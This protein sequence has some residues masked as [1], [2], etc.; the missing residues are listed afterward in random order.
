MGQFSGRFSLPIVPRYAEVDQ[1]GVVFNGHYLTWFD[2]ACTGLLDALGVAY[3]DL[4]AG[5]YDFQ[6]VHSEIDFAS[7]VR[8]RDTVR[9]TAECVR[10]GSTSFSLGF[11]VL[12]RREGVDEHAAVRGNN[13]YVVVSTEDWRKRPVPDMLRAALAGPGN[14]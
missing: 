3:P 13:V 11:A 1:Q 4:M 9:V 7:P 14:G 6:V 5:G 8:W 12:T 10:V 2:E